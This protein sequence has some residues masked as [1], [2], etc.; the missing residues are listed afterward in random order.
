[1]P[2][3]VKTPFSP[4]PFIFSNETSFFAFMKRTYQG[5]T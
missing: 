1:M 5:P 2:W 4:L 3:I